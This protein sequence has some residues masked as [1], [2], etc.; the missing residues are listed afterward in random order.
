MFDLASFT[1]AGPR[2]ANEDAVL[3]LSLGARRALLAVA[4]GLG[5][6]FGGQEASRTAI[7]EIQKSFDQK[8]PSAALMS[9][10]VAILAAQKLEAKN[11]DMAT[12]AT[13]V[14]IDG[15]KLVGAHCGDTR[16]VIQRGEGIQKL[17]TEH[18]EAQRLYRAGKLS[19]Q[20][21]ENYPRR[22]IL[23]SALGAGSQPTIDTFSFD[24]Q[25]GDKIILTSDGVHEE[26]KL[27]ELLSLIKHCSKASEVIDAI[28]A[29][30][31]NRGA[32]DNFSMVVAI[33][34]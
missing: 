12:T 16:C 15:Y 2:T 34:T 19:K 10:H 33:V 9:A 11:S 22:N 4:D 14:E 18:T 27:R 21:L 25:A 31:A 1:D 29:E 5:G 28:S 17:T 13:A 7:E 6:H 32:N 23:V 24:V 20:E 8:D 30:I 26:I 3:V